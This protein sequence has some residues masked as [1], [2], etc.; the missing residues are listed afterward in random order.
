M[1]SF[2]IHAIPQCFLIVEK[3]IA[4][5]AQGSH[6]CKQKISQQRNDEINYLELPL[7]AKKY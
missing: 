1:K 6:T 4:A 2:E 3:I 5:L 7:L